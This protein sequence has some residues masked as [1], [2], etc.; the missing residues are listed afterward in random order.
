MAMP[1]CMIIRL[2]IRSA[3]PRML[4]AASLFICCM[5][6][7]NVGPPPQFCSLGRFALGF[8][9]PRWFLWQNGRWHPRPCSLLGSS[10]AACLQGMQSVLAEPGTRPAGPEPPTVAA[11]EPQLLCLT[12]TVISHA[13]FYGSNQ[14]T[15]VVNPVTFK[16]RPERNAEHAFY[17]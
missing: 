17:L 11:S 6:C 5:N 16:C 7:M 8:P 9:S 1:S 4:P 14:A 15:S 3:V 13:D 2:L 10:R 12:L